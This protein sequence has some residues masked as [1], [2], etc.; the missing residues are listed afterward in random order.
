MPANSTPNFRQ[1]FSKRFSQIFKLSLGLGLLG[2]ASFA[3]GADANDTQK[4]TGKWTVTINPGL[5]SETGIAGKKS[6]YTFDLEKP[7]PKN[8]AAKSKFGVLV[9]PGAANAETKVVPPKPSTD[10][11]PKNETAGKSDRDYKLSDYI[12]AYDAVPF[13]RTEYDANPSYRHDAA[14]ELLTGKLRKRVTINK[15]YTSPDVPEF[16][17]ESGSFLYPY[18][19]P[20][21]LQRIYPNKLG[22]DIYSPYLRY[23]SPYRYGYGGA[24]LFYHQPLRYAR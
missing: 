11:K 4:K 6:T 12:R 24:T 10:N 9:T 22:L 17:P 1:E 16:S 2:W 3:N 15:S 5:S 7:A 21:Y 14:I 23:S 19:D 18:S 13:N 8:Q 20:Y